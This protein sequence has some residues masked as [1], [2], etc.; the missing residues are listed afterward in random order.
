M[1]ICSRESFI[2]PSDLFKVSTMILSINSLYEW[3]LLLKGH[4][5]VVQFCCTDVCFCKESSAY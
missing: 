1:D 5:S 3:K 2:N 4:F